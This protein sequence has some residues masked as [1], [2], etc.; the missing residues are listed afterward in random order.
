MYDN[1]TIQKSYIHRV[2]LFVM[3]EKLR[4]TPAQNPLDESQEFLLSAY[5]ELVSLLTALGQP[6]RFKVLVLLL[7]GPTTFQTL[8]HETGLK[9]SALA[10]HL[11]HLKEKSL[12]EK[13]QHGTYALT[14]DG[15]TYVEAI[16]AAYRKSE[17]RK[18][19]IKEAKQRHE[20]TKTFLERK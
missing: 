12:I 16:E 11:I 14:D 7:K 9:K 4:T 10:N 5:D 18:K 13:I 20:L 1:S 3:N 2:L 8:R 19:K 6:S 15:R 17:A